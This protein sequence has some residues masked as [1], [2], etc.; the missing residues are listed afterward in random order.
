VDPDLRRFK[1]KMP[2][3]VQLK[4]GI[5]PPAADAAIADVVQAYTV[6]PNDAGP[7]AL[8]EFTGALPRAK[9]YSKWEIITNRAEIMPR[10]LS[11]AFDPHE[12]VILADPTTSKSTTGAGDGEVAF[13]EYAPKRLVLKSR[14]SSQGIV[15]LN[16]RW[17]EYWKAE[18]DHR[19]VPI[20][21]ANYL[22]RAVEVGAGEHTIEF[23]FEPP[24]G[25]FS[26]TVSAFAGA[27]LSVVILG[28]GRK[29][30][31]EVK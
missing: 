14:S 7:L 31:E 23:R 18:V 4:P 12:S 11:P 22:M 3:T 6:A 21:T 17:N 13:Q 29:P 30:A 2:Y 19:P 24:V 1:V 10:L 5:T 26:A 27:G 20:L 8:I 25:T 16:D 9:F 28:F 15:L